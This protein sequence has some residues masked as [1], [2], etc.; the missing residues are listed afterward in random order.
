MIF[1]TLVFFG[2]MFG[3]RDSSEIFFFLINALIFK[4]RLLANDFYSE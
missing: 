1:R 2:I 3:F 4:N